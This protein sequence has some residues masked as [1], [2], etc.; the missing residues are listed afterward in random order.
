MEERYYHTLEKKSSE[1]IDKMELYQLISDLPLLDSVMSKF[2]EKTFIGLYLFVKAI[3]D[4]RKEAKEYGKKDYVDTLYGKDAKETENYPPNERPPIR[5]IDDY[6]ITDQNSLKPTLED[7][8]KK[9]K[10]AEIEI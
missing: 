4:I 9:S 3:Y 10:K 6:K 5:P 8:H 1:L 7:Y 2:P